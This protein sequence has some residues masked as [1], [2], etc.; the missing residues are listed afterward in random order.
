MENLNYHHLQY[1]WVTARTGSIAKASKELLLAPPTI[2]TQ[3]SRLED[4]L[5]EKLFDRVG[6]QL[7][8]TEIG[9]IAFRYAD[10][11]FSLGRE[12][13]DTVKGRPTGRPIRLVIGIADVIPKSIVYQL[14]RSAL[15]GSA[16]RIICRED[17]PD[18]MLALLAMQEL[19]LVLTD[20]PI[21]PGARF[22]V[23]SHLLGEAGVIFAADRR[24]AGA[25]KRGFPRSLDGAPM[26][27]PTD[28][29]AIR[30]E[31]NQWFEAN[32]LHPKIVGEFEDDALLVECGHMGMGIIP[33]LNV[34]ARLRRHMDRFHRIGSTN[35][36][37]GRIY[38]ISVERKLK[39]PAVVTI[40][41]TAREKL[42]A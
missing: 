6:R 20:A 7:V 40:C 11:I 24:L 10:E 18:R 30:R 35:E 5:G 3:I 36:V 22:K 16:L 29:T 38:A 4:T 42:F 13:T 21:A 25:Y 34:P 31:L 26:L 8:L 14:I 32:D 2:S 19:D 39:H 23:F 1:F 15:S 17:P 12:L 37:C 33:V 9:K 27:L 28:N 41:Q